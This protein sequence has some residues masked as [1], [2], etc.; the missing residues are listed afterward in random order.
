MSAAQRR[1]VWITGATSGIGKATA[2]ACHQRGDRLILSARHP[3]ALKDLRSEIG[4]SDAVLAAFDLGHH[5]EIPGVTESVWKQAGGVDLMIHC[6]GISQRSLLID[7]SHEVDRH[8]MEV[9]YFGTLVL[10][11]A[12]LPHMITQG[13]GHFA[14]VTSL[15]GLF[16]APMRSGYA[17]AKHALHGWFEALRAEHHKDNIRVTMVAPG[18]V[19]TAISLN[20]LTAD[21]SPQG[22]MDTAT[23]NGITASQ[24]AAVILR[25]VDRNKALITPGKKEVLGYWLSRIAPG[26][27]RRIARRAKVT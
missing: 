3:A 4:A 19:R 25:G 2:Q 22:T 24:C 8:M 27:L 23:E 17:G 20:A 1:T 14:V 11:R 16:S 21:G 10:T 9:N 5:L 18:F 13:H 26:L 6:G 15:M 7:T 12:L